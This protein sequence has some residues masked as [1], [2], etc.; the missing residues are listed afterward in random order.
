MSSVV[1]SL[2]TYN[3]E[4]H[5][6]RCLEG[7]RS[8]TRVDVSLCVLDNASSDATV[9][10]VRASAPDCRLEISPTNLGFAAG[11]NRILQECQ[12][13]DYVLVLNQDIF[14]LPDY[15]EHCAAYLDAHPNC[16]SVTGCLHKVSDLTQTTAAARV[17]TCGLCIRANHYIG[18]LGGS[19]AFPTIPDAPREIFGAPGAAALYRRSAL[20]DVAYVRDGKPE[21]FDEDFFMYKED[22]DLAYRLAWRG[23]HAAAVPEARGFHVGSTHA[24]LLSRPSA[25]INLWS[26]RNHAL[27]LF[28]NVSPGIFRACWY[29]IL[30]YEFGKAVYSVFREPGNFFAALA[31]LFRLRRSVSEKRRAIM[32]GRRITDAEMISRFS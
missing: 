21:F 32:A 28:K 24:A 10:A 29:R 22:C 26:Y 20:E 2:V 1:I 14:L 31:G 4:R 17:D 12:A 19:K 8:Q 25:R 23:W 5:I 11:H 15:I 6:Q 27:L 16:A 7:I 13:A 18:A 9:A 30:W 3:G